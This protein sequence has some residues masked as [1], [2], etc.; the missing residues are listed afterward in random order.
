MNLSNLLFLSSQ[1]LPIQKINPSESMFTNLIPIEKGEFDKL[2]SMYQEHFNL[3]TP[4]TQNILKN[5]TLANNPSV[6]PV[7]ADDEQSTE[8]ED[9][10]ESPKQINSEQLPLFGIP[11]INTAPIEQPVGANN[12]SPTDLPTENKIVLNNI[13]KN[14]SPAEVK[15]NLKPLD[16]IIHLQTNAEIIN[17]PKE[18]LPELISNAQTNNNKILPIEP[19]KINIQGN[20][21]EEIIA[22]LNNLIADSSML[23]E[24]S[25]EILKQVAEL[26]DNSIAKDLNIS[27]ISMQIADELENSDLSFVDDLREVILSKV[28]NDT[29]KSETTL[30]SNQLLKEIEPKLAG[31]DLNIKLNNIQIPEDENIPTK[32]IVDDFIINKEIKTSPISL[33]KENIADVPKSGEQV[34]KVISKN[35]FPQILNQNTI[36]QEASHV[37]ESGSIMKDAVL[38]QTDSNKAAILTTNIPVVP[39]EI[40]INSLNSQQASSVVDDK[41]IVSSENET[42]VQP[43]VKEKIELNQKPSIQ[44]DTH[45]NS[46]NQNEG[47]ITNIPDQPKV[48]VE[49]NIN[50][51]SQQEIV[52]QEITSKTKSISD[53]DISQKVILNQIQEDSNINA[54]SKVIAKDSKS[55]LGDKVISQIKESVDFKSINDSKD[56]VAI[57]KLN[58][59]ELG[60]IRIEIHSNE[61]NFEVKALITSENNDVKNALLAN[62]TALK[63]VFKENG[64]N[65]TSLNVTV[66]DDGSRQSNNN[67]F[68]NEAD[69][70]NYQTSQNNSE[71]QNRNKNSQSEEIDLHEYTRNPDGKISIL[72]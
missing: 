33:I 31:L 19:I 44:T 14:I 25:E 71:G 24:E 50:I 7:I 63:N 70:P 18:I 49:K 69:N 68:K 28:N 6:I 64:V 10:T 53:S 35:I 46:S 8:T 41:P 20:T 60:R 1:T 32:A 43:I 51:I 56:N 48:A 15:I 12:S 2:L 65:F 72:I 23:P 67:F 9:Q 4:P 55:Q 37:K 5:Q 54:D 57:I 16:K 40:K 38:N 45:K 34:E 62:E 17:N 36:T 30:Q 11:I 27:E 26:I 52:E 29:A 59:P 39:K 42:S 21:K 13:I 66:N 58:P 61:K 3:L 22:N 47:F